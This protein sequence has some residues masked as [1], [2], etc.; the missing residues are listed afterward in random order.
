MPPTTPDPAAALTHVRVDGSAA[1]V[2]VGAK[3]VSRR[4]ASASGRVEL[5][6]VA[7]AAVRDGAVKKGDVLTIARIAGIQAA[8]RTSDLIPLCHPIGLTGIDVEVWLEGDVVRLTAATRVADRTGVEMEALTA[9]AV[10][11]LT[12]IDMVKALDPAAE[13]TG[14]RVESKSG[15][16]GG[17]WR[18]EQ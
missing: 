14:I 2:D 12:V 18:R 3:P 13:L 4:E 8:K 1:M 5:N 15:G 17:D 9:V 11:G 16:A 7:A 10:A 6:R